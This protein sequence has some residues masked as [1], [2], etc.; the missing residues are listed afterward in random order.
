MMHAILLCKCSCFFPCDL[1]P[2]AWWHQV[3][4]AAYQGK[5]RP[6]GFNVTASFHHPQW[7]VFKARAVC[8][9]IHQQG[10]NRVAVV[11]LGYGPASIYIAV[12]QHRIQIYTDFYRLWTETGMFFNHK[13]KI[14]GIYFILLLLFAAT[15][16]C[17]CVWA[18]SWVTYINVMS[19]QTIV[20]QNNDPTLWQQYLAS[21]GWFHFIWWD[22]WSKWHFLE[23]FVYEYFR[24][25]I[26]ITPLMLHPSSSL[27]LLLPEKI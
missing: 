23:R 12:G 18:V 5:H 1:T 27:I 20:K 25:L 24:C 10:P 3:Q 11:W 21:P 2:S 6:M 13:S 7:N 8:D 14:F 15:L 22:L 9:I 19:Q 26:N 17:V 4:L 16:L